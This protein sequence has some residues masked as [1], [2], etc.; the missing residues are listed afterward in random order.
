M[1]GKRPPYPIIVILALLLLGCRK[2]EFT[3]EVSLPESVNSTYRVVYYASDARGGATIET[4]LAV[5]HGKGELKCMAV[6]PQ[7]VM[8]FEGSAPH[9]AT[10][11]YAER[12]DRIRISGES[13]DASKWIAEGNAT[14][15]Q[16]SEWRAGSSALFGKGDGDAVNAALE[17]LVK[18]HPS[19][20]STALLT[21]IYYDSTA[22]GPGAAVLLSKL[23]G[24]A[25]ETETAPL[26]GR[27]ECAEDSRKTTGRDAGKHLVV[28]G[29][30]TGADTIRL[31]E[32]KPV[33]IL[34]RSFQSKGSAEAVDSLKSLIRDYPDLKDSNF[35]ELYLSADSLTWQTSLRR[36]TI[37]GAL[38]ARM[39]RELADPIMIRLGVKAPAWYVVINGKGK[40]SYSGSDLR[41]ATSTFRKLKN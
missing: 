25:A 39:A 36:D 5:A 6:N 15:E 30:A 22:K 16:M 8:I 34:C 24:E 23:T 38:R 29:E 9:P 35:A 31:R 12:G 11:F 4:A 33:F 32:G 21:A 20:P 14:A 40:I 10:A 17:K 28:Q 18:E 41:T 7:V 1:H 27:I 26:L 3:I 13:A 19:E 2:N 37:R